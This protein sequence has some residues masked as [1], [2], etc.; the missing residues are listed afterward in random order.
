MQEMADMKANAFDVLCGRDK[1]VYTHPGNRRFR[2]LVQKE[3]VAYQQATCRSDK[4]AIT[5]RIIQQ[6]REK[7]QFLKFDKNGW[8]TLDDEGVYE[9]VSHALRSVRR[10]GNPCEVKKSTRY[11]PSQMKEVVL[12]SSTFQEA[13]KVQQDIYDDLVLQNNKIGNNLGSTFPGV[14]KAIQLRNHE[15]EMT[16]LYDDHVAFSLEQTFA[17]ASA[18]SACHFAGSW[19]FDQD[20]CDFDTLLQTM[21]SPLL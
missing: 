11:S 9:K 5:E 7:G 15:E 10:P 13:F 6:V 4:K 19:A 21:A 2:D 20:P 1:Q 17:P 14:E 18:P 3:S 16:F 12:R 8:T